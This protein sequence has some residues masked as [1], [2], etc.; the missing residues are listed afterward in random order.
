MKILGLDLETTSLD[1]RS[2]AVRE[3]GLCLWDT[4]LHTAVDIRSFFVR[5]VESPEYDEYLVCDTVSHINKEMIAEFGIEAPVALEVLDRAAQKADIILAANGHAY[6]HPV[7]D[8]F[9]SRY[10]SV[11][12]LETEW[13]DLM[14]DIPFPSHIRYRNLMYLAAAHGFLNPF[15]HRALFDVMTMLKVFDVYDIDVVT[16]YARSPW[17][18][19]VANVSYQKKDLAKNERFYWKGS[20][21]Q[22]YKNFKLCEIESGGFDMNSLPFSCDILEGKIE[23]EP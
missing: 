12:P 10:G 7:C 22:W 23:R 14:E 19:V 18:A 2:C 15:P 4:D 5:D 17:V 11:W 1:T 13:W 3:I 21:K 6:D 16:E 20:T 9:N 8:S